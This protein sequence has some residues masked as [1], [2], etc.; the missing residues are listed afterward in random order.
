MRLCGV[1]MD[2]NVPQLYAVAVPL[3]GRGG[4]GAN[5]LAQNR[6]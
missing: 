3:W 5:I 1:G 4:A 2:D 6:P